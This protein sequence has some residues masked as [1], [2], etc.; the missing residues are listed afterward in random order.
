M[1]RRFTE[2][3]M[4]RILREGEGSEE[5]IREVCRR[6]GITEQT[7][8][9]WRRKFGGMEVSD[10]VRLPQ[11]ERKN[12]RLKKLI[13]ERDLEIKCMKEVVSKKW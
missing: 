5:T 10:A 13:A 11:L 9:R 1:R 12:A 6:Q 4:I 2:E 7:F 3:E 8:F